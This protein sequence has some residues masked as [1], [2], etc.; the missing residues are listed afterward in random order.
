[1][2][3]MEPTEAL[4]ATARDRLA[5]ARQPSADWLAPGRLLARAL[6]FAVCAVFMAWDE[7]YKAGPKMHRHFDERL[8]PLISPDLTTVVQVVWEYEGRM[9]SPDNPP[10]WLDACE[11]AVEQFVRL[12]TN[13][14]PA[15]WTPKPLP[16]PVGWAGLTDQE[17]ALSQAA[18]AAAKGVCPEVL[19]ILFG[20]HAAGVAAPD[21]DYD[22][23]FIFPDDTP[24]GQHGQCIG[25]V[26][27]VLRNAGADLDAQKFTV[28]EFA[29][30]NNVSVPLVRRI[31]ACGIDVPPETC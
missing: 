19:L 22:I 3:Y 11:A 24:D 20:S 29:N 8:V 9:L 18:F 17:K 31:K 1:M 28:S 26:N 5:G 7:P 21:S 12:A 27:S 2:P 4:I 16:P 10:M 15:A 23:C 30:P 6:E 25:T 14:P 13:P